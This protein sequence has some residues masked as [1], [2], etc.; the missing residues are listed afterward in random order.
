MASSIRVLIIEDSESDAELMMHHLEK[1]GFKVT[2]ERVENGKSL[3]TLLRL[4]NG[5]SSSRISI[6][7]VLMR[8]PPFRFCRR[9]AGYPID[10]RVRHDQ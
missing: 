1:A 2:S 7:Q 5:T 3:T 6:C 4:R 10:Y 8:L 9:P